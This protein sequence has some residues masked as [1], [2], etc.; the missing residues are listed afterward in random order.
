MSLLERRRP[1]RRLHLHAQHREFFSCIDSAP[2][3]LAGI[4]VQANVPRH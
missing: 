3:G 2:Q 1:L 4:V